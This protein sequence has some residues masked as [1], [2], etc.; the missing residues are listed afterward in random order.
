MRNF[1]IAVLVAVLV[2]GCSQPKI[3]AHG[4]SI[5]QTLPAVGFE[6]GDD[7]DGVY[8][9]AIVDIPDGMASVFGSEETGV[10]SILTIR[11]WNGASS[12]RNK[13][14]AARHAL[15]ARAELVAKY[16]EP[17]HYEDGEASGSG[18]PTPHDIWEVGGIFGRKVK[19]YFN[20]HEDGEGF[21]EQY[22]CSGTSWS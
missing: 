8:Y 18:I 16:G 21:S 22:Y 10:C 2:G 4:F 17:N 12:Y 3:E 13:K 1:L 20:I 15:A 14:N 6:R 9:S 5:G 11:S 7:E 19:I